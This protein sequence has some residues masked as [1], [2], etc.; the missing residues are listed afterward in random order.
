MESKKLAIIGD[1]DTPNGVVKVIKGFSDRTI[2]PVATYKKIAEAK[3]L[4]PNLK[5]IKETTLFKTYAVY[6]APGPG[7]KIFPDEELEA[8]SNKFD[9]LEPHQELT[10]EGEII[11]NWIGTEYWKKENGR[12]EKFKIDVGGISVPSDGILPDVLSREQQGEINAQQE[13][14][15]IAA[16]SPEQR[17]AEVQQR[18]TV[19]A[20]EAAAMEKRAQIQGVSF[21]SSAWYQEKK[22]GLEAQ[23]GITG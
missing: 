1:M 15:R 18:L 6:L 4:N 14:D 16:L 17:A 23:Y 21:D 5:N 10:G 12:W 19:L 2:D 22:T 20:D 13:A 9:W 11:P 8:L 7:R 3:A